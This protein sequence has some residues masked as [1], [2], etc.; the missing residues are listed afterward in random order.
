MTQHRVGATTK[1][2]AAPAPVMTAADVEAFRGAISEADYILGASAALLQLLW[3]G[4]AG[5]HFGQ[6]ESGVHAALEFGRRGILHF[7]EHEGE[8]LTRLSFALSDLETASAEKGEA[9]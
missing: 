7:M 8:V 2:G 1:T 3:S 6:N 9:A 5:G 4:M